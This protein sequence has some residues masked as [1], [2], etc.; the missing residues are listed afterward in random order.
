MVEPVVVGVVAVVRVAAATVAAV[1]AAVAAVAA[2]PC[3]TGK[4][5]SRPYSAD[6]SNCTEAAAV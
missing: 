6:Q 1:G 5:Y 3:Q 4:D 2:A